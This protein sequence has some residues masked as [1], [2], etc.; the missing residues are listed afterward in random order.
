MYKNIIF[1]LTSIILA[2]SLTACGSS[3]KQNI[4]SAKTTPKISINNFQFKIKQ[5][6]TPD[7]VYHTEKEMTVLVKSNIDKQLNNSGLLAKDL[8]SNKVDIKVTYHRRFAGEGTSFPSDSLMYPNV[9][10]EVTL[11]DGKKVLKKFSR[12]QLTVSGGFVMNLQLMTG[13]LRD[14]ADEDYFID[15]V[16]NTLVKIIEEI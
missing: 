10:F 12:E 16:G 15:V 13:S 14:K 1:S 2:L 11:K 5:K 3:P 6:H 7:I 8:K 4:P 9:D